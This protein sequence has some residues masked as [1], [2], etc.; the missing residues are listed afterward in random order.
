M[1]KRHNTIVLALIC[2]F[3]S[4]CA[5]GLKSSAVNHAAV[6]RVVI[7]SCKVEGVGAPKCEIDDL[8]SVAKQAECLAAAMTGVRCENLR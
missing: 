7:E 6:T 5:Q 1:N 8:E 3:S 4:G 2:A